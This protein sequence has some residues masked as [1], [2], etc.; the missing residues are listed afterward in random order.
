MKL[1]AAFEF[2]DTP[3]KE[4]K[5]ELCELYK[6]QTPSIIFMAIIGTASIL[7]MIADPSGRIGISASK[8]L[9]GLFSG[10][11][12]TNIF[13]LVT[14]L[15][16]FVASLI[17][18]LGFA[19]QNESQPLSTAI[20]NVALRGITSFFVPIGALSILF[21]GMIMVSRWQ[22][23]P[24]KLPSDFTLQNAGIL[25]Y[26]GLAII[27]MPILLWLLKSMVHTSRTLEA[28]LL[29]LS[30]AFFMFLISVFTVLK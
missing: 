20:S 16:L 1:A 14:F 12:L 25:S 9:N 4:G 13:F 3:F 26:F 7:A 15:I 22:L 19:V 28:S 10:L 17:T 23:S 5:E 6:E 18:T 24:A 27:F 21:A 30:G 8:L 2:T 29:V 11:N